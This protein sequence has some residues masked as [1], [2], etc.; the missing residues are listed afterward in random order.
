M[1]DRSVYYRLTNAGWS[2]HIVPHISKPWHK[3]PRRRLRTEQERATERKL[4]EIDAGLEQ[5]A[6]RMGLE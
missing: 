6:R 4:A 3:G 1:T 2:R 5:I